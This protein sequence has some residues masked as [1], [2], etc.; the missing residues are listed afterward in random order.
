MW[1]SLIHLD[2]ILV[3]GDRNGSIRILLH[4]YLYVS[5]R[6]V[7]VGSCLQAQHNISN[8]VKIGVCQWGRSQVGTVTNWPFLLH[9]CPTFLFD[10]SNLG[11]KVL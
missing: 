7:M 10:R 3:Q 5:Q 4:E 2:L 9:F 11:L 6:K 1:S 8:S